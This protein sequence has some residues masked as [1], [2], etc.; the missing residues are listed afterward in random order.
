MQQNERH[1]SAGFEKM[2]AYTVNLQHTPLRPAGKRTLGA[3]VVV[4]GKCRQRGDKQHGRELRSISVERHANACQ[5]VSCSVA[6]RVEP[7]GRQ[8]V[9]PD[10]DNAL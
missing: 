2:Q 8:L 10:K 3:D 6:R 4:S 7:S 5:E 9:P 1:A